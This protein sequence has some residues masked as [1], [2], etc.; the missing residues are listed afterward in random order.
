MYFAA[1]DP[2]DG[3]QLWTSNGTAAGTVRVSD[4]NSAS[5][6]LNP[7]LLTNVNGI[8]LFTG[9]DGV[10][11]TQL[12]E[13]NGTASGTVMLDQIN[14]AT[15]G[16]DPRYLMN[17]NGTLFFAASRDA[18]SIYDGGLWASNGTAASTVLISQPDPS[19]RFG[20]TDLTNVNGTM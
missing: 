14:V 19:D 4:V 18:S 3:Y 2:T 5:F 20:I 7:Q 12:W 10:H 6:G 9:D 11:G 1:G 16:A 17:I 15:A 8:L 13:S